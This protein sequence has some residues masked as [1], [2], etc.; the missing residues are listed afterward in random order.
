M[1][2]EKCH[3][4][5][6]A[7]VISW[8]YESCHG[9]GLIQFCDMLC[10]FCRYVIIIY[11]CYRCFHNSVSNLISRVNIELNHRLCAAKFVIRDRT[12]SAHVNITQNLVAD[13]TVG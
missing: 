1:Q 4:K 11:N 2:S 8:V 10:Y 7:C 9:D 3:M 6:V 13:M 5:R 12:L